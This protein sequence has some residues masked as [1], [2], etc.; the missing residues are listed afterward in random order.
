[1]TN[2]FEKEKERKCIR[3]ERVMVKKL[4]H[5]QC[6]NCSKVRGCSRCGL[7]LD[8]ITKN[9]IGYAESDSTVNKHYKKALCRNCFVEGL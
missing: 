3:C 7:Y 9:I 2:I 1:M 4:R 5:Y 6:P 8:E